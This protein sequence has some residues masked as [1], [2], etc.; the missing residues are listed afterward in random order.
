MRGETTQN[1]VVFEIILQYFDGFVRPEAVANQH[2]WFL[3][4]T[5]LNFR[6]KNTLE[7]L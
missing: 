3:V 7:P 6:V 4:S 5:L 1:D 2:L